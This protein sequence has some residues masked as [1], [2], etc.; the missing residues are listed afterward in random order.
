M[1]RFFSGRVSPSAALPPLVRRE[2]E[3]MIE[4]LMLIALG[5]LTA[6][7]F[8]L[9]AIQFVWRRAVTVTTRKLTGDIDLEEAHR[10]AERIVS[11]E[12]ALQDSQQEVTA[13]TQRRTQ[14]ESALATASREAQS[15]HDEVGELRARHETAISEAEAHHR[16]LIALQARVDE[17][18]TAARA[19]ID[20]RGLVE[21]RIR[22]LG[23]KA[24]R[25]AVEMNEAVAQLADTGSLESAVASPR[26]E[27]VATRRPRGS[28]TPITLAP[29]PA[30][31]EQVAD[32]PAELAEIKASL[33][34]FSEG[35]KAEFAS[36]AEEAEE[37][38]DAVP[39]LPNERYLAD[40][41]RAL[42]AG[43]AS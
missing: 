43:V 42:E 33:K 40:R 1:A 8:A 18:E 7:L 13:L 17:L 31:D 15:L 38:E 25:L 39:P 34:N 20:A 26:P 32:E 12:S 21:V 6:T 4:S 24:A 35:V 30:D 2:E 5:F 16:N 36:P 19:E 14:L 22:N 37:E 41:I 28:E 23:E 3:P 27:P 11:L 10:N 29:F 9:I